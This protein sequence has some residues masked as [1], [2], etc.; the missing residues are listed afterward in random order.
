VLQAVGRLTVLLCELGVAA[1][2]GH[3][4]GPPA[5]M[6]LRHCPFLELAEG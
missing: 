2:P 6:R 4:T 5:A 1:N 3:D